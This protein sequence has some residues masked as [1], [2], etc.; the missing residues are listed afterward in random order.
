MKGII[1]ASHGLLADGM[2]DTVKLF[3]GEPKQIE[4]VCLFP[5]E[6]MMDFI[7]KIRKA[8]DDVDSGEGVIVFCDLLF[9]TP[10]NCSGALLGKNEYKNRIQVITGMNLP[11]I[12]EYIG[13][14]ENGMEIDQ[15]TKIGKDGI[16]DFN[17]LY[18][19]RN[20]E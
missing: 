15:I 13:M 4:S 11:M 16:V 12:L 9:G 7:G 20:K 5:G 2:L 14:R 18:K 1:L 19:E 6:D 17:K 8:I 10:C 3:S